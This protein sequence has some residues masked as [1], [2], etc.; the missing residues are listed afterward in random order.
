LSSW[1]PAPVQHRSPLP[2]GEPVPAAVFEGWA[3]G[4][5]HRLR[6]PGTGSLGIENPSWALKIPE[7]L[8]LLG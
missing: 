2:L 8:W 5:T 6:Q 7:L 1:Q 3:L 4:S